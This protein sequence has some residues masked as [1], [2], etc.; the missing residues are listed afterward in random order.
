MTKDIDLL[1]IGGGPAGL[2]SAL[3]ASSEGINTV[4][5]DNG[6]SLGGQAR[7]SN[8][9][10]NYPGFP[11]GVTGDELMGCFVRQARDFKSDFISPTQAVKLMRDDKSNRIITYTDDYA[12]YASKSAII[13]IGLQYR[14]LTVSGISTL[15]GRGIY[16]G[17]PNFII[18]DST[19]RKI[20]I[21]GGANS[22]GQAAVKLAQ[23]KDN[24]IML[25]IRSTIDKLMSKYLIDRIQNASNIIVC[26]HCEVNSVHGSTRLENV[27]IKVADGTVKSFDMDCMF[28]FIG[29]IPRTLWLNDCI[30]LSK[31]KYILTGYDLIKDNLEKGLG[32]SVAGNIP[33]PQE[34]SLSGVFA[35]G[36]VRSASAKR[37]SV[38]AGEGAT[39]VQNVHKFLGEM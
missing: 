32:A 12:E 33:L 1:V 3:T 34:T 17:A 31:D 21:I 10:E 30:R 38:A 28:I 23:N 18:A 19:P 11:G 8:A 15:M 14:R 29:A 39:A 13:S 5:L 16:Y 24:E 7:E 4:L 6:Q 37:V 27:N 26:E 2:C 25:V 20:A 36:D 35:A 9:I 22:A